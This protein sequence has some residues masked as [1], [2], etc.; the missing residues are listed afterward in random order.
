[1]RTSVRALNIALFAVGFSGFVTSALAESRYYDPT[2]SGGKTTGYELYKTIGCPG[3]GLLDPGCTAPVAPKP[4]PTPVVQAKP[5]P[6]PVVPAPVKPVAAVNN[7]MPNAKPGECYA[8]V[9]RPPVYRTQQVKKLVKEAGERI[10]IVPP[11]YKAVKVHVTSEETQEVV[12]AVYDKVVEHV[13]VKP[14][15]TRLEPVPAVYGTV[16]E[17]VMVK[18]ASKKAIDV[19]AVFEDVT[20]KKLV[21]EAYTYWKPG[22]TTS[23]QKIDENSGQIMCLVEVPAEYQTVTNHVLKTPA[24]VRYEEIP[25]EYQTV[26][27]SMLKSPATT[28]SVVVPAEYADQEVT[29]LIKPATTETKTVPVDY[30][31]EVM[32]EVTPATEKRVP[33]PAEYAMVDEQVLVSPGEE[34][35]SQILCDVNATS[36]KVMEI[37]S[38]LKAAGFDPG[39]ID[40]N[41]AGETMAAVTAYQKARGLSEDGYLTMETVKSLGVSA[42]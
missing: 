13:M 31:R 11:V 23:I 33:V 14:A 34:H 8:K 4:T 15:T 37:Q 7:N 29:K 12:P 10:E 9:I 27:K 16:E 42:K 2:N 36:S 40:G 30:M 20:E 24:T 26:T 19:P 39:P 32:T 18:P 28:R 21:H 35:W 5:A 41:I 25:A 22:T 1:M 6:A 38:A 17:K 3:K